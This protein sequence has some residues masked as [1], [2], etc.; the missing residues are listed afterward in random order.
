MSTASPK[1]NVGISEVTA[2]ASLETGSPIESSLHKS[3]DEVKR[4]FLDYCAVLADSK[5]SARV[6]LEAVNKLAGLAQKGAVVE[7]APL[8]SLLK[9]LRSFAAHRN[10]HFRNAA[11][12]TLRY[13]CTESK[14]IQEMNNLKIFMF[15][16][17]SME[18]DQRQQA[19]RMQVLKLV[20]RMMD[21][22]CMLIPRYIVQS[23]VA[24]AEHMEDKFRRVCLEMLRELGT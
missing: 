6:K 9:S 22:D 19:E 2:A 8:N 5:A 20:R 16:V 1:I 21:V 10:K 24:I 17:R 3:E 15:I 14:V 4:Q 12:R 7:Y 11:F 18:L 23:L 13:I